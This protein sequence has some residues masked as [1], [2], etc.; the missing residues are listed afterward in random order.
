VD[1]FAIFHGNWS[2]FNFADGHAA[3]HKWLDRGTIKAAT[4]SANGIESS[5]WQG[6]NSSN[7]DFRWVWENYR[8]QDWK[9]LP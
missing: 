4:D 7:P 1:P 5:Y 6:G 3:G 2:T 8:H 9:P